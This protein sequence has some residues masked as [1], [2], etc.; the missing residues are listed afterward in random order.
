MTS[1]QPDQSRAGSTYGM[2]F[3]NI[4]NNTGKFAEGRDK[5]ARQR[6]FV[7]LVRG[8]SSLKPIQSLCFGEGPRGDCLTAR[9]RL[10]P[11]A[12]IGTLMAALFVDLN[13]IVRGEKGIAGDLLPAYS[14][15]TWLEMASPYLN[16]LEPT[17]LLSKLSIASPEGK[18]GYKPTGYFAD[19][20]LGH[21][22]RYV[23]D[24]VLDEARAIEAEALNE[25]QIP[26]LRRELEAAGMLSGAKAPADS[27]PKPGTLRQ[28]EL[29]IV[30]DGF[31][32]EKVLRAG[33]RLV[34]LGEISEEA[35]DLTEWH[36][37]MEKLF[38]Q[39]PER[40]GI[41]FSGA[42]KDFALPTDDPH[43]LEITLPKEDDDRTE[44]QAEYAYRY[45]D[46]SFH[47]D[48]PAR[49]DELGV[50]D[51]ANA[52]ARF[53]LHKQTQPP[54]TIGIHGPWGKGKS[55]FMRLVDS[56]LIKYA[57]NNRNVKRPELNGETRTQ[58]WN[59]VV[60]K[61]LQAESRVQAGLADKTE[62]DDYNSNKKA[63]AGLWNT[64]SKDAGVVSV[65]F[66]AWQFEDAKQT[67]AGLASQISGEMEKALPRFSRQLLKLQYAW[68]ERKTELILNILMPVAVAGFVAALI[69]LGFFRHVIPPEDTPLPTLVKILLPTSSALLT[70]WFV[71]SQILK[72]AEPISQRVLS[73]VRLPN[74]REQMGFQHRVKDDLRF[75]YQ[76]LNNRR[77]GCRVVVYIDDLDRCSESKIMEVL[78]AINLILANCEFFVFVGMDT[79]MIYRAIKA[80]YK[81]NVPPRFPENYL[82]KIVQI[83]FYLPKSD[84]QALLG[85]LGTLFSA[86]ARLE[87]L[88][89][90]SA[91]DGKDRDKPESSASEDGSLHYD[92]AGL[93]K[94]VPVQLKEA[95]DT[96]DEL[97]TFVDYSDFLDDNPREIKRLINIHRLIKILV[98]KH[99]TSWPG[100]RQRKLVKWL[101][102]CDTWPDL[103]DDILDKMKLSQSSNCLGD[104]A[105]S[106]KDAAENPKSTDRVVS[107]D[108]LSEFAHFNQDHDALSGE[109]IDGGFRL[110]AYLS[111]LVR[112]S[113][114]VPSRVPQGSPDGVLD[115][116]RND[117]GQQPPSSE[118]PG[119]PG[120]KPP[121]E[122][123]AGKTSKP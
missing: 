16:N 109:D 98:Q 33:Q 8:G 29:R 38:T 50:N 42:P 107:F 88:T 97:Q 64:M 77:P 81:D 96:A 73:Y 104:L 32:D 9:Y 11:E 45:T 105:N 47:R 55:S 75:V 37:A 115:G 5:T 7:V 112:K 66:N 15:D 89:R 67:W 99:D 85:Y 58:T 21:F 20:S 108:R 114:A 102:F 36:T 61:L 80:Y 54:L 28:D 69:I 12:A 39:L 25:R 82:S 60:A 4:L 18:E 70:L 3:L 103:V 40:V 48:E 27:R 106:L 78:Q 1:S 71:S 59:D 2:E 65:F 94:I 72:V 22:E 79:E 19:R 86:T 87:L 49:K 123:A 41:V 121:N 51:Y 43:F 84:Q 14:D 23:K 101:I 10:Q 74:Y 120:V 76:F 63:E 122:P 13:R 95:E 68:N 17:G 110:A 53:I 116:G 91:D 34:L 26:Q 44:G 113:P 31:R 93:L 56:A 90:T 92:L 46:S 6:G 119:R 62:L 111:Q 24:G 52:I 100:Q 57:D 117:A 118:R 83:S 30:C 35:T